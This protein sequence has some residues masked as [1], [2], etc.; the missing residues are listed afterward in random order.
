VAIG[1]LDEAINRLIRYP[2]ALA[3][4]AR[5][6]RLRLLGMG[7]GARCFIRRINVPRNPWDIEISEGVALDDG[8]VLLTT[9]E[10]AALP[11]IYFASGTYCNRYTMIDASERIEIGRNCMIGPMCYITDHDHGHAAGAP[12]NTQALVSKAVKICDDVWMGA[13]AIILKG[14]TVGEGAVIGAGAV[15]TK[16][17]PSGAIFAG[18]AARQMVRRSSRTKGC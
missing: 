14:V 13:G 11:R 3:M 18:V 12:I 17:V 4:R 8:V 15:V 5:I 9:G 6:A 7:I 16:D 10:R 1:S 2:G